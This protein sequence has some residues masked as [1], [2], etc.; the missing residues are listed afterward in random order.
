[1][2]KQLIYSSKLKAITDKSKWKDEQLSGFKDILE[3]FSYLSLSEII[4]LIS[5]DLKMY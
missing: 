5:T 1:M 2:L 3:I 4:V